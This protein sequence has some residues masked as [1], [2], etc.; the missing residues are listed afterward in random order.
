MMTS[1][2]SCAA[3]SKVFALGERH[4]VSFAGLKA[5]GR[6]NK[7]FAIASAHF[8]ARNNDLVTHCNSR[9]LIVLVGEG[10]SEPGATRSAACR[11]VR[12]CPLPGLLRPS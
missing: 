12:Y 11:S 1:R 7:D 2:W 6:L 9:F 5:M 8:H 3:S 10:F 4:G